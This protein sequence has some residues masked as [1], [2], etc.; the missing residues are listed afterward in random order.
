MKNSVKSDIFEFLKESGG[1]PFSFREIH[2]RLSRAKKRHNPRTIDRHLK[3]LIIDPYSQI[4]MKKIGKSYVVWYSWA[5]PQVGGLDALNQLAMSGQ[6]PIT[7]VITKIGDVRKPT[8]IF[9]QETKGR[10]PEQS[11]RLIA[12]AKK[13]VLWWAGDFSVFNEFKEDIVSFLKRGGKCRILMNITRFSRE[14]ARAILELG[15]Q[16]PT[17]IELRHWQSFWRGGIFDRKK[18]ILIEKE[19][20]TVEAANKP[21]NGKRSS[22]EEFEFR[23]WELDGNEQNYAPWVNWLLMVWNG[24]WEKAAIGP[25]AERYIDMLGK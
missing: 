14:N 4:K 13:E 25:N 24:H 15:K 2:R 20:L 18:V 11:A 21:S 6:Y 23:S 19:A 22:P 9:F 12:D 1:E 16:Y 3:Q 10:K 5:L 7:Q 17:Q 8:I